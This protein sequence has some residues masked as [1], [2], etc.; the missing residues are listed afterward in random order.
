M[1]SQ[2]GLTLFSDSTLMVFYGGQITALPG[3]RNLFW[4]WLLISV[5]IELISSSLHMEVHEW[6]SIS[7]F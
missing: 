4:K 2:Y 7:V 5:C 1:I 6:S 3:Q